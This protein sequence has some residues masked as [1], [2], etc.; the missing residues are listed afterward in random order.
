MSTTIAGILNDNPIK[1]YTYNY[2]K[3][4]ESNKNIETDFRSTQETLQDLVE[5]SKTLAAAINDLQSQI[6]GHHP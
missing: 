2:P 5:T 4:D 3:N 1:D 6:D